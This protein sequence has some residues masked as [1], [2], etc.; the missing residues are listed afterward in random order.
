[1]DTIFFF[2]FAF[3]LF[4]IFLSVRA[5]LRRVPE[6][7]GARAARRGEKCRRPRWL[8]ALYAFGLVFADETR[9]MT[10]DAPQGRKRCLA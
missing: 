9:T 3:C 2:F 1:L 7:A 10:A 8:T 5:P 6:A 4:V